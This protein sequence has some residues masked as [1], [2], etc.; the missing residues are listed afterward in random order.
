MIF[1]QDNMSFPETT[2]FEQLLTPP[3][4]QETCRM[5]QGWQDFF[6]FGHVQAVR[7][8]L[9]VH[10]LRCDEEYFERVKQASARN[11]EPENGAGIGVEQGS[12][13]AKESQGDGC[14]GLGDM[15]EMG[16]TEEMDDMQDMEKTWRGWEPWKT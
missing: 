1:S 8:L 4:T 11:E 13:E 2:P 14:S 6:S 9:Q 16:D 3:S 7:E 5:E 10:T 15:E 12:E